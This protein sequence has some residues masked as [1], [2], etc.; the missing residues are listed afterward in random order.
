MSYPYVLST[1]R[2][3]PHCSHVRGYGCE[4]PGALQ[5]A[6]HRDSL[7]RCRQCSLVL[8]HGRRWNV[9]D[10]RDSTTENLEALEDDGSGCDTL[11]DGHLSRIP[12]PA[13]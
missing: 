11:N 7:H 4:R 12:V 9:D 6:T 3:K 13:G 2:A 10:V 5:G 8:R 1:L